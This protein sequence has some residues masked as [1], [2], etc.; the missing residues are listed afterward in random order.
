MKFK[1]MSKLIPE[2]ES[3]NFKIVHSVPTAQDIRFLKLRDAVQGKREYEGFEEGTYLELKTKSGMFSNVVM[4]DTPMELRTNLDAIYNSNGDILIGGL[5]IGAILLLIQEK[6]EVKSIIV[7]EK[8]K[9]IIDMVKPFL[10]LNEKVKIIEADIFEWLPEKDHKFDTI[11]F[12]IWNSICSDNLEDMKILKKRFRKFLNKENP[13]N[14]VGCWREY[15]C[16]RLR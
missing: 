6:P 12:D 8:Y 7:I 15:D 1:E 11:Y 4:S 14:W 2:Q 10:P 16:R 9:E 3:E 5:G 13:K